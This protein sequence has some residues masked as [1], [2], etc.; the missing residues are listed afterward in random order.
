MKKTTIILGLVSIITLCLTA[1]GKPNVLTFEEALDSISYSEFNEIMNSAENYEQNF[2]VSSNF[3]GNDNSAK[4]SFSIN[5]KNNKKDSEW[6]T[7]IALK[8]NVSWNWYKWKENTAIKWNA[9]IR[10]LPNGIYFKLNSLNI[11]GLENSMNN[12]D[13]NLSWIINQWFSFELTGDILDKIRKQLP[14][15]FDSNKNYNN[16]KDLEKLK[17]SLKKI[18]KNEWS[19]VYSGVYSEF[20]WCKARKISIDKEKLLN[21]VKNYIQS[22]IPEEEMDDYNQSFEEM[23]FNEMLKDIPFKNFKWYLV[24]TKKGMAQIVI[25]NLDIKDENSLSTAKIRGTFGNDRYELIVKQE[26]DDV[27]SFSA[28]L[29]KTHYDVTL[30]TLG[31]KILWWTITPKKSKWKIG[32]RFDLSINL[33]HDE[34][35]NIPLNGSRSR[36]EISTFRVKAPSNSKNLL[37]DVLKN[38]DSDLD[39]SNYQYFAW[40]MDTHNFMVPI[41]AGWI[42]SAALM[43]RMQAAQ[44]RA[45]D[46]SRKVDLSQ[47]QTAIITS[48]QDKWKWPGVN[49]WAMKWIPVSN[50]EKDLKQAWMISVPKDPVNNNINYGLWERYKNKKAE[51][52]YLYLIAKRNWVDNWWFVL[53]AKTEAEWSSNWVVCENSSWLNKWYITNNSDLSKIHTCTTVSKWYSC[54]INE[55]SC[56]YTND[57]ELR[58]IVMY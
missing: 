36:K 30:K 54:W 6:E 15:D 42:M 58:Y 12:S 27:L 44:D 16:K 1:C 31:K 26:G 52:E 9:I 40:G 4:A 28:K 35:M 46:V 38:M 19:V 41:I 3:S 24:I 39:V 18:I 47:I 55:W 2:K 43:P 33:E 23:D 11:S 14:E 29:N 37:E 45:R 53:M 21:T 49:S 48:Q 17:N 5:S 34:K 13:L 51:W 10:Y 22:Q 25:E 57:K 7:K 56:T 8:I 50:I 20:N 32:I